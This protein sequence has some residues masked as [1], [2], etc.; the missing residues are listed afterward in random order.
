MIKFSL[1]SIVIVYANILKFFEQNNRQ[2]KKKRGSETEPG[3]PLPSCHIGQARI[4]IV[5]GAHYKRAPAKLPEH[6]QQEGLSHTHYPEG[7]MHKAAV[8]RGALVLPSNP[9]KDKFFF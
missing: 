8:G 9:Y 4:L 1:L 6:A 3:R 7:R 5:G 2:A